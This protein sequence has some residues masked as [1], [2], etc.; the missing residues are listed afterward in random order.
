MKF[1][2]RKNKK[3]RIK[4]AKIHTI[5][6]FLSFIVLLLGL[7]IIF[8]PLLPK[9]TSRIARATDET[10]GFKYES[11]LAK[12]EVKNKN[13]SLGTLKPKPV[14]NTLVIPKIGVD[15]S[16]VE[17]N[18]A[19]S[20]NRGIWRRPK[21]S[22]PDK[23][24]NTVLTGHRY[25]YTSGPNTFYSLDEMKVGDKFIVFWKG[26][27]Y[28]YEVYDVFVVTPDK[29]EIE[30]N[31]KDPIVTLYTCTPIWTAKERLVVRGKLIHKEGE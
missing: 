6:N 10:K 15:S 17:G 8:S 26:V 23:G 19:F 11:D 16:I 20:L 14:E 18:D 28:D 30:A 7:Y 12:D 9:L 3:M 5:N 1:F 2:K 29:I 31:T 13:I 21:T 4:R 27:E 22:T 24:G 25:M